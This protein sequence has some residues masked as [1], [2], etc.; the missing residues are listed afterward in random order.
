MDGRGDDPGA[1]E[2]RRWGLEDRLGSEEN[3]GLDRTPE[4]NRRVQ[5]NRDMEAWMLRS[6]AARKGVEVAE[7]GL[8]ADLV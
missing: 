7:N 2:E 4:A 3:R 8:A 1:L 5:G 6:F